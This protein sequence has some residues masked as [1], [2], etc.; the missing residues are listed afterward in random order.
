MDLVNLES[1]LNFERLLG[2]HLNHLIFKT[3]SLAVASCI[4][5]L[6][7]SWP[8]WSNYDFCEAKIEDK[9]CSLFLS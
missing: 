5:F 7:M 6:K 3:M 4:P 2:H 9:D 1:N 8:I